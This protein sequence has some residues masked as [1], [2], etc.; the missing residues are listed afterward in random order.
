MRWRGGAAKNDQIV[1][2]SNCQATMAQIVKCKQERRNKTNDTRRVQCQ[3]AKRNTATINAAVLIMSV[4]CLCLCLCLQSATKA[5]C[6]LFVISFLRYQCLA[7]FHQLLACINQCLAC[8]SQCLACAYQLL[9]I[10]DGI[11]NSKLKCV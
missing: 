8:I 3:K 5:I 9:N 7:G 10:C 4:N 1:D 11:N 2:L 6:R